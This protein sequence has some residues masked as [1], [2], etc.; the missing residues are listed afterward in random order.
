M[1]LIPERVIT[2]PASSA[3]D[4]NTNLGGFLSQRLRLEKLEQE[5]QV[6]IQGDRCLAKS[7]TAYPIEKPIM[8]VTL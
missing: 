3:F 8:N 7:D 2:S 1:L 4:N 6:P 5:D